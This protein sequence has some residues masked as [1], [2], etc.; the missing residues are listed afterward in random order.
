MEAHFV[1]APQVQAVV[2]YL[3]RTYPHNIDQVLPTLVEVPSWPDFWK[4]LDLDGRVV[5]P[6]RT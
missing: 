4:T 6:N 5:P 1:Q 2:A 3:R